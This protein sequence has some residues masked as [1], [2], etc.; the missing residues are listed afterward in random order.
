MEKY[1]DNIL[2]YLQRSGGGSVHWGELMKRFNLENTVNFIEPNGETSNILKPLLN[3]KAPL[4]EKNIPLSIL[5]YLP[6]T[7]KIKQPA[8]FHSSYYRFSGQK[9]VINFI[10][11]HDFIY[12]RFGSGLSKKVHHYQKGLA[13]KNSKNIICV[14]NTTK[15]D[16]LRYF[17][18][19]VE[20]KEIEVIHN[21][22]SDDFFVLS[23]ISET[24]VKFEALKK[25]PYI[26]FVG[27]RTSYK[28][29]DFAVK[30][31]ASLPGNYKMAIVGNA[32]SDSE[33]RL[34]DRDLNGRYIHFGNTT[35]MELNELY[36]LSECLIYPSSYEGFGI[37]LIEAFKCNC[38]VIAQDIP[39]VQEIA[40]EA[41][42]LV[43]GLNI[44]GFRDEIL[45]LNKGNLRKQK[46]EL[47]L[48]RS[49]QFSWDKC[50]KQTKDFYKI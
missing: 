34:L 10:T 25:D 19:L 2:F 50:Y 24:N 48:E 36:N 43:N 6:L 41:A 33:L 37:P 14:S 40:G 3:L 1:F 18:H 12:E 44:D 11:V 28:N 22:V 5:R 7:L 13:V 26:L 17:P 32:L 20:K 9:G 39:I 21:G 47:G 4:K 46:I 8:I 38:P 15:S 23:D 35:N 42:Y 30:V 16:L 29:F 49:K 27:H 45:N 31:I